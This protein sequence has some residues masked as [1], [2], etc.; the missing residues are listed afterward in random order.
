MRAIGEK[1]RRRGR[2][3]K[4]FHHATIALLKRNRNRKWQAIRDKSNSRK[5][6]KCNGLVAVF[7]LKKKRYFNRKFD[8]MLRKYL[9]R[10][11]GE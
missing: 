5:L 6:T 9:P 3:R 2:A 7:R 8:F 1:T 4:I 10:S 11:L